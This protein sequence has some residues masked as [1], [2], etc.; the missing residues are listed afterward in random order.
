MS[1]LLDVV[2]QEQ[3]F[4]SLAIQFKNLLLNR[5]QAKKQEGIV[6]IQTLRNFLSYLSW[7]KLHCERRHAQC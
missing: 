1:F 7:V 6:T 5:D 3:Y 4:L 2:L